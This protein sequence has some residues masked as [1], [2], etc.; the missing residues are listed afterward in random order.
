MFWE[1]NAAVG[2]LK[3]TEE[4]L[5]VLGEGQTAEAMCWRLESV[6]VVRLEFEEG[7]E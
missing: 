7:Q 3:S 2:G 4:S 5:R 1:R 6:I